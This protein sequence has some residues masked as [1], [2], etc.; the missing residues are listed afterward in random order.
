MKEKAENST[1]EMNDPAYF[2]LLKID[3]NG[4]NAHRYFLKDELLL[5]GLVA[6]QDMYHFLQIWVAIKRSK[7]KIPPPRRSS[8][9]SFPMYISNP[10]TTITLRKTY[11]NNL[12]IL[13]TLPFY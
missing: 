9:F 4:K 10:N 7:P 8:K 3:N 6:F 13:F 5:A 1:G 2:G 11:S 12:L